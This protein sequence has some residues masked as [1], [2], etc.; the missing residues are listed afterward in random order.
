MNSIEQYIRKKKLIKEHTITD[1]QMINDIH[2]IRMMVRDGWNNDISNGVL[3]II[4]YKRAWQQRFIDRLKA[5]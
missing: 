2:L 1:E 4:L 5:L 3:E